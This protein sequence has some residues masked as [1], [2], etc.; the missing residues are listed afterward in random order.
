MSVE[1][2]GSQI[3][4]LIRRIKACVA[5]NHHTEALIEFGRAIPGAEAEVEKLEALL[6]E[7]ILLGELTWEMGE[8]R[9]HIS[10]RLNR[11]AIFAF[12][13]AELRRVQAAF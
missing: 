11:L 4:T 8:K 3:A 7:H 12:S 13:P 1:F 9:R 10:T 6:E 2:R 5:R